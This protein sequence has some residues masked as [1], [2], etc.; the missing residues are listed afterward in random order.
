MYGH[1]KGNELEANLTE[2]DKRILKDYLDY[3][4]ITAGET[5]LKDY[6]RYMLQFRDVLGKPLDKVTRKDAIRFWAL[7]NHAPHETNTKVMIKRTVKRFLKWR[8]KD[9]EM[10]QPL[11]N[12]SPVV[13][14]KKIN[15][16]SLLT[17]E[18]IEKMLRAAEKLRDKALLI[19]LYESGARPQEIRDLKW[20][21]INWDREE[22][23]LYS[24]KKDDDRDVPLKHAIMHLKRWKQ[25]WVLPDVTEEDFIFPSTQLQM[26]GN[27]QVYVL[28]REKT[29]ST[30]YI[31]Q[32]LKRLGRKAGINKKIYS[33]ILRHSRLSEIYK[34]GVTGILHNKFSGHK[35]GSR[36]QGIYVHMD[37]E[38]MRESV[39]DKV[40]DIKEIS[41]EKKHELEKEVEKLK[42]NDKV[43][44][45]KFMNFLDIMKSNP[46]AVKSIARKDMVKLKEIFG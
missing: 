33:Y 23:H 36:S 18:D 6:R 41:L 43:L 26:Q 31:S 7:V 35:E 15:K 39:L 10:I 27:Q 30:A 45:K 28:K 40:Y 16:N 37:N 3:C 42:N 9:L 44:A 12:Q 20:K 38:D 5:K 29:I 14:K 4:G 8:Y 11:I 32:I 2:K 34:K 21:D 1:D 46:E 17:P 13:N 22:V 24:S 25:E 19:L